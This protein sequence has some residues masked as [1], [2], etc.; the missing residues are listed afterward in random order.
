M[1]IIFFKQF[2]LKILDNSENLYNSDIQIGVEPILFLV[3]M[4][5]HFCVVG[6]LIF[7]IINK[8]DNGFCPE[9]R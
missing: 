6:L 9:C 5:L 8:V 3:L 7:V 2:G 4:N 1:N